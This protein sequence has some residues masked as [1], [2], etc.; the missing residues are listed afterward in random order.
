MIQLNDR[1]RRGLVEAIGIPCVIGAF[2]LALL[3]LTQWVGATA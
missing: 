3:I 2:T 1:T